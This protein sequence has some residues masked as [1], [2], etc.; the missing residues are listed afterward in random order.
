LI[1]VLFGIKGPSL[2]LIGCA[3]IIAAIVASVIAI[4][5]AK[6]VCPHLYLSIES[7][8]RSRVRELGNM[9]GWVF[10][11]QIGALL[12]LQ[13]DLIVVNIFFGATATGDYAIVLTWGNQLRTIA[14]VLASVLTPMILTFYAREHTEA[15]IRVMKSAVKLMGLSLA[16]PIGL[17][18]G[19][20]PQI[21]TIWVGEK[22][23]FLAPL[24]I[25]LTLHL[26]V[27]RAVLPIFSVNIAYNQVRVP[28]IMTL[29]T[30]LANIVLAVILVHFTG[31]GLYAVAISGAIMLTLKDAIFN[32][33]YTSKVLGVS[34]RTFS[35][36]MLPG[37][38][39]CLLLGTVATILGFFFP[40]ATLIPLVITG[41]IISIM[42][43][44]MTW[45][46]WLSE[47]ERKLFGSYLPE[48]IR[49][50]IQ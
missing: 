1:V 41:V 4:I 5:F 3:Y 21:L 13:I 27:N 32:P 44:V 42:Y 12:L 33:W 2:E 14:V 24:M 15:M 46:V 45:R 48:K 38:V 31:L 35:V 39:A 50:F 20:A 37:V 40:L 23:V 34:V 8:D 18:C 22:Y 10:I 16:L 28:G 19:F 7:F 26:I 17:V 49:R 47:R 9:G 43:C 11:D 30:G 25:I 29:I 36:E 6:R